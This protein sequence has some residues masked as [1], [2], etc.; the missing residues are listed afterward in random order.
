MSSVGLNHSSGAPAGQDFVDTMGTK[1]LPI[2]FK[3][4]GA[5]G[6]YSVS[7]PKSTPYQLRDSRQPKLTVQT[8]PNKRLRTTKDANTAEAKFTPRH[9]VE[10]HDNRKR[11]ASCLSPTDLFAPCNIKKRLH[12]SE[13]T[14]SHSAQRQASKVPQK[15]KEADFD[16]RPTGLADWAQLRYPEKKGWTH[17]SQFRRDE[18]E[19]GTVFFAQWM[20]PL[21]DD[22]IR[23]GDSRRV[24]TPLGP[25]ILKMRP[26]VLIGVHHNHLSAL[27]IYTYRGRGITGMPKAQQDEHVRI[28]NDDDYSRET[29]NL[30][31]SP[32]R[33]N[34][35]VG[36]DP[37]TTENGWTIAKGAAVKFTELESIDLKIPIQPQGRLRP[38]CIKHLMRLTSESM[39]GMFSKHERFLERMGDL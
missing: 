26:F 32:R 2:D 10:D 12:D 8:A 39:L 27:P 13:R 17:N 36:I 7:L 9:P 33:G 4:S 3:L 34:R 21:L 15:W 30:L 1:Q 24:E 23:E 18:C 35:F 6:R 29:D 5:I 22:S 19:P 25:L 20:K 11:R 38:E 16:F 28:L 31:P 14:T 37:K